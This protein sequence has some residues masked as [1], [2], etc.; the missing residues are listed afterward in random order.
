M[1]PV[2]R[3]D[4]KTRDTTSINTP[5]SSQ[6]RLDPAWISVYFPRLAGGLPPLRCHP[7]SDRVVRLLHATIRAAVDGDRRFSSSAFRRRAPGPQFQMYA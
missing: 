1:A 3:L 6:C 7:F 2:V 4:A 5:P